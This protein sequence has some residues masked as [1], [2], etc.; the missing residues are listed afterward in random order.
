MQLS[1]ECR[2]RF[3]GERGLFC[4]ES[5]CNTWNIVCG[6]TP[7]NPEVIISANVILGP[8]SDFNLYVLNALRNGPKKHC[9]KLNTVHFLA[10]S[11]NTYQGYPK[12]PIRDSFK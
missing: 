10:I 5:D 1:T 6:I 12:T 7:K 2:R 8:E 11:F 3:L 4:V 9:R